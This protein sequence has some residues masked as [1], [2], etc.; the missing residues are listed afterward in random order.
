MEAPTRTLTFTASPFAIVP[1][2]LDDAGELMDAVLATLEANKHVHSP[3][4]DY[5]YE[6]KK[7]T[8]TF[9]VESTDPHDPF[10][11]ASLFARN[12]FLHALHV[13]GVDP[14]TTGLAIVEGDD[15]EKLP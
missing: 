3:F 4:V 8:A 2:E 11:A 10:V 15:A 6:D 9:Q 14:A 5:G 12:A 13:A 1:V 7:L